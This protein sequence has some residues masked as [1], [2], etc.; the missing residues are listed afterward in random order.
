[1]KKTF[2]LIV[3]AI[4]FGC[5]SDDDNN[6]FKQIEEGIIFGEISGQCAGDCRNL[7]L[8][9]D[10]GLFED[11]NTD[12]FGELIELSDWENTT[13]KKEPLA[14]EKFEIAKTLLTIPDSIIKLENTFLDQQIYADADFFIHIKKDN[15]IQTL[16]FD[17]PHEKADNDSKLYLETLMDISLQLRE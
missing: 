16:V 7:F 11:S 3:L 8:L 2:I 15:K 12:T 14:N 9:T 6:N 4:N 13:F 17:K 10:E 1:M 5:N